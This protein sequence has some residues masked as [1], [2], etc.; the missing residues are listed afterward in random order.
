MFAQT[1]ARCIWFSHL[2]KQTNEK[3]CSNGVFYSSTLNWSVAQKDMRTWGTLKYCKCFSSD[4]LC[5]D[6][7]FWV[8]C[9]HQSSLLLLLV[10][11]LHPA[12]SAALLECR[13]SSFSLSCLLSVSFAS[14]LRHTWFSVVGSMQAGILNSYCGQQMAI[15]NYF[16]YM[17]AL[18]IP[19][20]ISVF[21]PIFIF[22]NLQVLWNKMIS[23]LPVCIFYHWISAI[24][25]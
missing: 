19:H 16:H 23:S 15:F 4:L 17:S 21:F 24:C 7:G 2:K 14:H 22:F 8:S 18:K 3:S 20:P 10:L 11:F 6:V 1:K 25:R 9:L 13:P 5:T 12:F